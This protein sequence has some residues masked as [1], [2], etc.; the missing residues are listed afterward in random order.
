[1]GLIS[2]KRETNP[3]LKCASE[4]YACGDFRSAKL[5]FVWTSL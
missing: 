3:R 1:M 2:L 4:V 5:K